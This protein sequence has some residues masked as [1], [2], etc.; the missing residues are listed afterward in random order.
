MCWPAPA[1]G[2]IRWSA[3]RQPVLR[4]VRNELL[5]P[6]KASADYGVVRRSRDLDG[7][8]G[9]DRAARG[10]MRQA[11]GWTEVPKVQWHDPSCCARAAE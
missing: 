5:S 10:E 11:R 6:Q 7:R 9:R 8:C 2:A 3:I 4:D 1:A